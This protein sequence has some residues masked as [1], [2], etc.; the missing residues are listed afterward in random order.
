MSGPADPDAVALF[1]FCPGE[2]NPRPMWGVTWPGLG[3]WRRPLAPSGRLRDCSPSSPAGCSQTDLRGCP[4]LCHGRRRRTSGDLH[5]DTGPPSEPKAL[6]KQICCPMGGG[7]ESIDIFRE[8]LP[9]NR[10][11]S[12]RFWVDG[13]IK[14]LKGHFW[15][16]SAAEG[17]HPGFSAEGFRP[18]DEAAATLTGNSEI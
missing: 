18:T 14:P 13:H 16:L 2:G 11:D 15:R 6:G 8:K 1:S 7:A 10:R 4:P 17:S 3:P 12:S 5:T 9:G